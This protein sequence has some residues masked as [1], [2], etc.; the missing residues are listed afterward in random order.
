M[1]KYQT[2]VRTVLDPVTITSATSYSSGSLSVDDLVELSLDVN[3]TASTNTSG[4]LAIVVNRIGADNGLYQVS[5]TQIN[6]AAPHNYAINVGAGF[7]YG[8]AF[9]DAVQVDLAAGIG[10]SISA[11]LSMKGKG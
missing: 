1:G 8:F 4:N 3:V 2:T 5:Y 10:D 11:T 7:P 9:G 6:Y